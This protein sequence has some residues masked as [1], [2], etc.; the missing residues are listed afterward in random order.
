[1]PPRIGLKTS[2]SDTMFSASLEADPEPLSG[3]DYLTILSSSSCLTSFQWVLWI[4]E[5]RCDST[6]PNFGWFR[7]PFM[8]YAKP[9]YHL[10]LSLFNSFLEIASFFYIH[11]GV[12][13]GNEW[14]RQEKTCKKTERAVTLK[15]HLLWVRRQS[16]GLPKY[17]ERSGSDVHLS[18]GLEK[19]LREEHGM[20]WGTS[21]LGRKKE[22]SW[23]CDP[24]VRTLA[25]SCRPVTLL[26]GWNSGAWEKHGS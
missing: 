22:S 3:W 24:G 17:G 6:A 5:I 10:D 26:W 14:I 11:K 12:F 19:Q 20:C 1:M 21:S 4:W 18:R 13:E 23:L 2:L 25:I 8:V 7:S 16:L 9:T 15:I